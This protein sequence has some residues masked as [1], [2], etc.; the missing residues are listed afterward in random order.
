MLASMLLLLVKWFLIPVLAAFCYWY[1]VVTPWHCSSFSCCWNPRHCPIVNARGRFDKK[2]QP[3]VALLEES[4]TVG[5]DIGA[6]VYVQVDHEDEPVIDVVG[7]FVDRQQQIPYQPHHV[8]LIMSNGK[9]LESMGMALLVDRGLVKLD[10][11][12]ASYWPEF[13][14]AGKQNIT[15]Q[16]ILAHRSGSAGVFERPPTLDMFHDI[17]KLDDFLASTAFVYPHDGTVYYRSWT[18]SLYMDAV[19]RRVEGRSLHQLVKE[20]IMDPLGEPLICP[21][22]AK[23]NARFV[24]P[25][26]IHGAFLPALVLGLLPQVLLPSL[27]KLSGLNARMTLGDDDLRLFRGVILGTSPRR[28]PLKYPTIPFQPVVASDFNNHQ[29]FL[30][31]TLLSANCMSNARA[32]A[33]AF[34]SFFVQDDDIKT[35]NATNIPAIKALYPR[36]QEQL[37]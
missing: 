24:A 15:I 14:Q 35:T 20:D 34:A 11:P 18:S 37:F 31:Y 33:R 22:L 23:N 3:V 28:H 17:D 29:G 9:I 27:A 7:G 10:A 4:L 2:Y 5:W 26:Q 36:I 25:T 19:C 12:V 1:F 6:S 16:D 21:P 13:A 32:V 8:N 30:S